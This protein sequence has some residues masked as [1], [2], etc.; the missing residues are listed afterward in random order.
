MLLID[1][2]P[3]RIEAGGWNLWAMFPILYHSSNFWLDILPLPV[4][5]GGTP[6]R[7][8]DR[9]LSGVNLL[10]LAFALNL[11]FVRV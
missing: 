7:A 10:E 5:A 8:G 6:K 3:V 1:L 2:P 11:P 9:C 4:L